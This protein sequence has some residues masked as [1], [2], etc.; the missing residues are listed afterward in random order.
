MINNNVN[1]CK[2]FFFLHQPHE[3]RSKLEISILKLFIGQNTGTS[4]FSLEKQSII[5]IFTVSEKVWV[6]FVS[7]ILAVQCPFAEVHAGVFPGTPQPTYISSGVSVYGIIVSYEVS[8]I[9]ER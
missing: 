8:N 5:M 9:K 2:A 3:P 1:A 4:Y 6:T 7:D